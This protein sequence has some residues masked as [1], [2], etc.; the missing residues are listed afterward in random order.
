MNEKGTEAAAVSGS[1][2]MAYSLPT[3]MR[4]NRPFIFMI[5]EEITKV[6]L[7]LGRVTNPTEL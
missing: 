6:L 3:T 5:Y 2:I 7:F 4:I 1:E